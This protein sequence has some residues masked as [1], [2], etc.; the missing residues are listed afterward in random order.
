MSEHKPSGGHDG[1]GSMRWLLTYADMVTLLMVFFIVLYAMSEVDKG[2]YQQVSTALRQAL[3][4]GNMVIPLPGGGDGVSA[5]PVPAPAPPTPPVVTDSNQ[6]IKSIG[7]DLY[8]DFAHDGRFVVYISERGLTIS[9]VGSAVFDPGKAEIKPEFW[10]LLD[11]IAGK[12]STIGNDISVEGFADSD[13]IHTQE[14]PSNWYLASTRASVVRDYVETKGVQGGR[15][16][17]VSYGDTRPIA[18]NATSAGKAKNR[19]VDIVILKTK[20]VVDLG[21]EINP[22]K[23]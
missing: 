4:G 11:K 16:I 22:G 17:L 10:P 2:K 13:P 12:L 7:E 19:R 8:A 23:K 20:Q 9:L 15:L 6:L 14:F 18:S 5:P 21:Q 1:G 3:G